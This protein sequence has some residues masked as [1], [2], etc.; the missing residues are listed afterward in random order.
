MCLPRERGDPGGRRLNVALH[1]EILKRGK[2]CAENPSR[3]STHRSDAARGPPVAC[4]GLS[5]KNGRRGPIR[6]IQA[7][8][9]W[10]DRDPCQSKILELQH[11][12]CLRSLS[13]LLGKRAVN[14]VIR[15]VND[16]ESASKP[17]WKSGFLSDDLVSTERPGTQILGAIPQ[18]TASISSL[19]QPAETI[20]ECR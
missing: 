2:N 10:K 17:N 7:T 12:M 14:A 1:S 13:R 5:E 9:T 18:G 19:V 20:E 4:H 3:I 8:P 11:F 16:S 6:T 15:A